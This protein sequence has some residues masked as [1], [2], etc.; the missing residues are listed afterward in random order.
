MH[1]FLHFGH[2]VTIFFLYLHQ[3]L[4]VK[5]L[6]KFKVGQLLTF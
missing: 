3:I 5:L 1:F 6:I 2:K 4:A